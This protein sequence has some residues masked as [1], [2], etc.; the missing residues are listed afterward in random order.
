MHVIEFL[1][2]MIRF[3]PLSWFVHVSTEV[4]SGLG[5]YTFTLGLN[6]GEGRFMRKTWVSATR[7][8]FLHTLLMTKVFPHASWRSHI[9]LRIGDDGSAMPPGFMENSRGGTFHEQ[10]HSPDECGPVFHASYRAKGGTIIRQ[11]YSICRPA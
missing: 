8:R 3:F 7:P 1:H 11:W 10:E 2:A 6:Q 9:K 5:S 4:L